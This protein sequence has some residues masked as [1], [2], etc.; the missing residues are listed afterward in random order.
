MGAIGVRIPQ[1][2]AGEE[3]P[4][5]NLRHIL[6]AHWLHTLLP[7]AA[8]DAEQ[9]VGQAAAQLALLLGRVR[10][11]QRGD[12]GGAIDLDHRLGEVLKEIHQA[13]PPNGRHAGLLPGVHQH[14][15][16]QNQRRQPLPGGDFQQLGQQR[17]GRRRLPLLVPALRVDG[18]QP[19]GAS[20]LKGQHAPGMAQGAH[21]PIRATH[22]LNALLH[23]DLVEAK[24]GDERFGQRHADML[25]KLP[26]RRHI[27][28]IRRLPEQV[29]QGDERVRLAAA[30][31]ELQ[32]PHRL[33]AF[34]GKPHGDVLDQFPQRMGGIGEGE[35]LRRVFVNRPLAA[36]QGDFVKVGGEL[37]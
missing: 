14:F 2:F 9:V 32:L 22:I 26:H 28:Q 18:P 11:Q 10:G 27:R 5:Q 33:V 17:L 36:G 4:P 1:A 19:I 6:L 21:L 15:V 31:G 30:V 23:I 29:V 16:H 35:E 20:Q 24:R 25:P 3:A 8:E 34:P 13:L 7:L 12:D 37:G